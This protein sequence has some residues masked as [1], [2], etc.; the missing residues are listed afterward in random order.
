VLH[1]TTHKL[2]EAKLG[3]DHTDTILSRA[4][5]AA[6]YEEAGR[7]AEAIALN[8]AI[9][10]SIQPVF[11]QKSEF[12]LAI[13]SNLASAYGLAGR[14]SEAMDL[15]ESTLKLMDTNLGPDHRY[16]L[17]TREKLARTYKS[18]GWW[19]EAEAI[20]RDVAARWRKTDTFNS[21]PLAGSLAELGEVLLSQKRWLEAEPFLREALTIRTKTMPDTWEHRDA[22]SLLGADLLGQGRYTEA[23]RPIVEGYDGMK[24]YE[25]RIPVP[26]RSRLLAAAMRVVQLYE[27][28]NKPDQAAAWK[29]KLDLRDL[30]AKAF[31]Q[32][33]ASAHPVR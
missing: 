19:S 1:E 13:R 11:G 25:S 4:N 5:L 29:A 2:L 28:W 26:Y 7:L 32:P 17:D 24:T 30:P 6:L 10:A 23:E 16:T 8:K 21:V 3:P 14:L 15:M 20:L 12:T 33:K 22:M 31:A 27:A 18:L 9:L